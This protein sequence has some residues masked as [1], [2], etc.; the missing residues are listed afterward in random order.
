[1]TVTSA[2][3]IASRER[4]PIQLGTPHDDAGVLAETL[5]RRPSAVFTD[6]DGTI[7]QIVPTPAEATVHAAC[8]EALRALVPHVDLL[9]VLTGRPADEAWRML[10]IDDALYVG[11]H[12]AERWYRGELLRPPGVERYHARLARAQAMLRLSLANVPGLV[13]E[14]KG[15]GFAVHFRRDPSCGPQVLRAARSIAARRGLE[16]IERTAHV[17]VRAPVGGDKGTSLS[18]LA[19][20]HGLEGLVVLGDDPVDLPAFAAAREHAAERDGAV[21]IVTVGEG[22]ADKVEA[23][24][25]LGSPAEMCRLLWSVAE[26][27]RP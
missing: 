25:R 11:N 18:E 14:D 1:M 22:L 5:R 2:A 13:F 17:E 27:L 19:R 6:I 24:V 4:S 23:D 12:G 15:V 21:T 9:C 7:S 10:R 8:R 20:S 3:P 16:V 26:A